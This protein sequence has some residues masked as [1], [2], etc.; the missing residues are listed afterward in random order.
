MFN[1]KLHHVSRL[2]SGNIGQSIPS[3]LLPSCIV[4]L[5][6]CTF[7]CWPTYLIASYIARQDRF[8]ATTLRLSDPSTLHQVYRV[9]LHTTSMIV[10]LGSTSSWGTISDLRGAL[11]LSWCRRDLRDWSLAMQTIAKPLQHKLLQNCMTQTHKRSYT[12][13]HPYLLFT[14]YP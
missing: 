1:S 9:H 3:W 2:I 5:I 7:Y 13:V 10:H 12:I 8:K 6:Y 11:L 14:I 4:F